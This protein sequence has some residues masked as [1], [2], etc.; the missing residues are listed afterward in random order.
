V[1]DA[2]LRSRILTMAGRADVVIDD[3][4][5][6][7]ASSKTTTVNAYFTGYGG[8]S[9][10]VLWDTL[11]QKHPPDQVDV[12]IAHEMGHWV[13][14]HGL[15]GAMLSTAL[16]WLGLFVIRLWFSRV[17][18]ILGWRGSDDVVSYPYLLALIALAGVLSLPASNAASRVAENMADAFAIEISQEPAAAARLFESFASENLSMVDVS[19]WEKF[20]FYTHPPLAERIERARQVMLDAP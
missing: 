11:L 6:I 18:K 16:T 14:H 5:I 15:I 4:S 3:I 20:I 17:W 1:T 8:A 9:K 19:P 7:D 2:D 10:I 13:Y 12:V